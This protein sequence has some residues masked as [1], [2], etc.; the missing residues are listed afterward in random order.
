MTEEKKQKI[1]KKDNEKISKPVKKKVVKENV[2]E[3]GKTEKK[4]IEKTAIENKEKVPG[5]TEESKEKTEKKPEEK[6]AEEVKKKAKEEVVVRGRNLPISKKHSMAIGNFI[7]NKKIKDA[8]NDLEDVL[9]LKKAIPMKG[10]IPHRKGKIMSGRFP[11][12]ASGS[13]L[14]LLKSLS[15]NAEFNDIEEP[16]II[17]TISNIG[18]RP[19]GRFGAFRRKRTHIEIIARD[20]KILKK[21]SKK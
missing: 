2:S 3:K 10:E 11:K 14:K 6:K 20:K 9:K 21:Q 18:Q 8:I 19:Y 12:N 13:F 17:Q 1:G 4:K 16:V 15:S 5:K 7:K